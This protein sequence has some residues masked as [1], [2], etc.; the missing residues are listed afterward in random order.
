M[1]Y[2]LLLDFGTTS[3]KSTLVDLE[4]GAFTQPETH[5]ALNNLA[6]HPGRSEFDLQSVYER[7]DAICARYY[8]RQPFV[9]ISLCSEMHGFAVLD[10]DDRPLTQYI[11][12]KDERSLE[13]IQGHRAFDD[14]LDGFGDAFKD[15]TGMKPRPG[16]APMN[17][18]HV[19]REIS[20]PS[21]ARIVDLPG[22]LCRASGHP[23]GYAHPTMLA[24]LA[25]YDVQRAEVAHALIERIAQL[26]GVRVE[27]DAPAPAG[28]IAG[29]W[30]S[31]TQ[32]V[33]IY[34]G[35]GD[36]QCSLLGAGLVADDSLSINLGTGAQ[37]S[38]LD[39]SSPPVEAEV[40]PYFAERSLRTI[41]HIP[42]GRALA[43]YIGFLGEVAGAR[44]DF[45]ELLADC[46]IEQVRNSTLQV[47]LGL[48]PSARGYAG[49]GS[50][51]G[52][53]EGNLTLSNYLCSLLRAFIDQYIDIL[54]LFDPN[55]EKR[56]T[57]LSGGIARR[58]PVVRT[59]IAEN[60]SY[61]TE[62]ATPLDES[63]LGLRALALAAHEQ[64][65]PLHAQASFG[66][67][68]TVLEE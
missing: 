12:W 26:C 51:G 47:N 53:G 37:V 25:L 59:Y 45:W 48:F 68:C 50:I 54:R 66:R 24:G 58:L 61:Q 7:F 6:E 2:A 30:D 14:L 20:L 17:L 36:H 19:A 41:T 42:G 35:I 11:S 34:V 65:D 5:S 16:F 38:T 55:G 29:Y 8:A 10:A 18:L 15:L 46:R 39:P 1:T 43:E 4:T 32:R 49:G 56:C 31:G 28:Q 62:G 23:T 3:T 13:V 57:L 9:G 33:P 44:T 21:S 60:T 67:F 27:L 63:L 40:R 64:T 22:W 52:I